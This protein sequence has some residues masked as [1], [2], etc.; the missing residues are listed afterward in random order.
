MSI[1]ETV[2][3][4]ALKATLSALVTISFFYKSGP[5]TDSWITAVEDVTIT[6]LCKAI[7]LTM[8]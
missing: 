6:T 1:H 2:S 4:C 7:I 3:F 8:F 5:T